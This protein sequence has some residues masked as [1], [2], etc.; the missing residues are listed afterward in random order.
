MPS[1]DDDIETMPEGDLMALPAGN[2]PPG[3]L[4]M[5]WARHAAAIYQR[6]IEELNLELSGAYTRH[7]MLYPGQSLEEKRKR[8]EEEARRRYEE[9]MRDVQRRSD[10]LLSDIEFREREIEMHR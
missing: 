8:E 9:A 1:R 6:H 2:I 7:V 4:T 5:L 3:L 10:R